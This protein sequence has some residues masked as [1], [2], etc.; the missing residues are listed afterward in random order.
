MLLQ[1]S[2][3]LLNYFKIGLPSRR[4]PQS[5]ALWPVTC[6]MS[7]ITCV[8]FFS[9]L[10]LTFL[11]PLWT[12]GIGVRQLDGLQLKRL[13]FEADCLLSPIKSDPTS[14]HPQHPLWWHPPPQ[15]CKDNRCQEPPT[16][17]LTCQKTPATPHHIVLVPNHTSIPPPPCPHTQQIQHPLKWTSPD[18]SDHM[19]IT[20]PS[21][22]VMI[23]SSNIKIQMWWEQWQ[24]HTPANQKWPF[25]LW[26]RVQI[27]P[28]FLKKRLGS[29]WCD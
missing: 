24:Q 17:V 27:F 2:S 20:W 9:F 23:T 28:R 5:L 22:Y 11:Q 25:L 12:L 14:H 8:G 29:W 6:H 15:I 4:K 1:Y 13:L 16:T 26:N 10:P 18:T 19:I 21:D 7:H 3:F